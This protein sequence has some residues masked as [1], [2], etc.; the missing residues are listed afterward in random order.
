MSFLRGFNYIFDT[1]Q[2]YFYH[3][4]SLF[5]HLQMFCLNPL[6]SLLRAYPDLTSMSLMLITLY[7]SLYILGRTFRKFKIFL[8]IV[9]FLMI[10]L[11]T[12]YTLQNVF[13]LID[14]KSTQKGQL[15]LYFYSLSINIS[16]DASV[17]ISWSSRLNGFDHSET[18]IG[19]SIFED[20]VLFFVTPFASSLVG[21]SSHQ[22]I[23]PAHQ[24]LITIL[25]ADSRCGTPPF[26]SRPFFLAT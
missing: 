15:H 14:K 11:S 22:W 3:L 21:T 16:V 18:T 26:P 8:R 7:I 17:F 13:S 23:L 20:D 10:L 2:Q 19:L 6:Q 12:I 25:A 4:K 9:I 1:F 24:S 5:Y